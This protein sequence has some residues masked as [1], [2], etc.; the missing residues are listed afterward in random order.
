MNIYIFLA[1]PDD[2]PNVD[3]DKYDISLVKLSEISEEDTIVSMSDIS[4]ENIIVSMMPVNVKSQRAIPT[5]RP[6]TT[7]GLQTTAICGC[8]NYQNPYSP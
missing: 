1:E 5:G 3:L 2:V 8:Q 7:R 4:E 6:G